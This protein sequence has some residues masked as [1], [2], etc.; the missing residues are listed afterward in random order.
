[1][2]RCKSVFTGEFLE[3][4]EFK[5]KDGKLVVNLYLLSGLESYKIKVND[6][7]LW[8]KLKDMKKMQEIIV[9]VETQ[10]YKDELYFSALS[11]VS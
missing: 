7:E 10:T 1:M 9:N 4:E 5:N 2:K 11:L 6:N 3:L 8:K